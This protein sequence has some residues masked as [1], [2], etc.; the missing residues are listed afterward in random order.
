[1]GPGSGIGSRGALHWPASMVGGL[2]T[3]DRVLAE[4]EE[5]DYPHEV[6]NP[7]EASKIEPNVRV[8]DHQGPILHLPNERWVEGKTLA[9]TLCERAVEMGARVMDS[10]AVVEITTAGGRVTG[11]DT[12]EGFVG[13]DEVVVAAGV[14]TGG[15]LAP[16][17]YRLPLGRTVGVLA[18][19]RPQLP[20]L[21]GVVYPGIYHCRPTDDGGLQIGSDDFD[22]LADEYAETSRV[23]SWLYGLRDVAARDIKGLG[24]LEIEE[25]KIGMR[26]MPDDGLPLIG[27]VPGVE[28]VYAAVMHSGITLAAIVG[29]TVAREV[30]KGEESGVVGRY[31]LG[32]EACLRREAT[33][34]HGDRSAARQ[35]ASGPE[36]GGVV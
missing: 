26:P 28:G 9:R 10:C 25:F 2:K 5:W 33:T 8:M 21:S 32:R 24:K 31:G 23:P 34:V 35:R 13:A 15:L 7:A 36:A 22:A 16:L 29:Q 6:L 4:L 20:L 17:G 18:V 14:A 1:M 19:F 12:T 11:V 30:W 3:F 27:R